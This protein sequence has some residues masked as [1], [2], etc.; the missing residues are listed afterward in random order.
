M[1]KPYDMSDE[2][3]YTAPQFGRAMAQPRSLVEIRQDFISKNGKLTGLI[4][5]Q[6]HLKI[7]KIILLKGK[8]INGRVIT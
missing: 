8:L 6:R 3:D 1:N 4:F 5:L 2:N 7:W